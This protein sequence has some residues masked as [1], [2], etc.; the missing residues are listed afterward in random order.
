MGDPAGIGPEVLLKA[1]AD[2][3]VRAA[4][5]PIVVGDPGVLSDAAD[6][7]GLPCAFVSF[8]TLPRRGQGR[9]ATARVQP[10]PN[11][12][13]R[14]EGDRFSQIA[15][16]ASSHLPARQRVVGAP[17]R[18]AVAAACGDAAYAAIVEAVRLVQGGAAAGLVTAPI[19]KAHLAAA[20]HDFPGHTE[21]LA[22]LCGGA[23]VR[24][25]MAGPRLRVVLVTIHLALARV[26]RAVT[27]AGVLE[28]ILITAQALRRQF[29][30][31]R[32]QIAVTGLNPHA[33]EDGLFGSEERR[34]VAPAVRAARK[35]GIDARGPLAADSVFG[36]AA[37]G[38]YDAVVCMYHD[39][40]L[41]PFKLL[42]F[43]DGVNCTLGLPFVR[44]SPDHGTAFDIA[45]SNR[46][47]PRS[48]IAAVQL[49]ARL[50]AMEKRTA[51]GS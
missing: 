38:T 22:H 49:A 13:L 50:A 45:G 39:Q 6:R 47:D 40:G 5:E 29:G 7:L 3:T 51:L 15:V 42:H 31:D 32:P 16:V 25:M 8:P 30:V 12:L 36:Q 20:G 43:A 4:V 33:G 41:A 1:L 27:R 26:P 17:R 46:A 2:R 10:P 11:P 19:N 9:F 48:M 21:L 35:H 44:T 18:P 34:C 28:T 23:P 24:M 14:K 37:H